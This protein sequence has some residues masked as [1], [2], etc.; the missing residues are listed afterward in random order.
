[1][2]GLTQLLLLLLGACLALWLILGFW[3]LGMGSRVAL[4]MLVVIL[5]A[6]VG[7]FQ[8]RKYNGNKVAHQSIADS[9]LPPEDFQGA[10]ILVCG[11][12]DALFSTSASFR[13]TRQGWYLAVKLPEQLPILAQHLAAERPALIAQ[14][15]VLLAIVP[16]QHQSL[17]DFSQSLRA[18]QRAIVQ[19]K[20]WLGGIPPVWL[21]TWLSPPVASS[22]QAER[23][24]TVT[25][26]QKG[27]QVQEAGAGIMPLVQWSQY[28]ESC[29][30]QERLSSVLWMESL[31]SWLDEH[32][33]SI[34]TQRQGDVPA[35]TPCTWG[36]CFTPVAGRQNNLWQAH[37]S[38]V[39][40]LTP[41]VATPEDNLPL[42]EVLLPYLPRRR[43]VSRLML[44]CQMAG[45]LCGVFLL[46]ALL[47]SF[48]NNQRLVQ[49]VSDHLS[50]Y[51]RLTGTPPAPKALAQQQLRADAHLLDDWLRRGAPMRL[52]L[53][54][55]QGLRLR[56][57]L[58]IAINSWTPPLPPP[59]VI[60]QIVQGSQTLRLDSL[61]LF[62][63][64]QSML[65]SGSTK[66][67]INA[68]VG[69]KAKPGWLIVVAGHTDIT[70]D[71]KS[72]Q[73]LSLK[74]AE[75]VRNWMRDTGDIPESCFA[76]Q[77]YGQSRPLKS[78]DTEAGR[79]LNRRVE[80]SL[81][82]QADAC[83]LPGVKTASQD[84]SDVSTQEMEK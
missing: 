28:Q 18:W 26:G 15:S 8:W 3:P 71:D 59:P 51:N 37:I 75:S 70:G 6:A 38:E 1:M 67:L 23:W 78:N 40:T 17:D 65:K 80:I 42:P 61:S 79:A 76:V 34:L 68:L 13:E 46:F 16:E 33:L 22:A 10:V 41:R 63:V 12:S 45:V 73:A 32:V 62:D 47:A 2:R 11:D 72:N 60:N 43:G 19:C 81:V 57:P 36:C 29:N 20:G 9:T 83:R 54:L 4:S 82:P 31:L 69:I 74:R 64:G 52:S 5:C 77:G 30:V 7:Y 24:Y 53:G 49:S 14:I 35:L 56:A 27:I 25:P 55:Y 48:I 84:E 39:T 21:G 44:T 66:V 58:D 50:L